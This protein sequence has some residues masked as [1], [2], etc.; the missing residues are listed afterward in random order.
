MKLLCIRGKKKSNFNPQNFL[1]IHVG[2]SG[3]QT[4]T[5]YKKKTSIAFSSLLLRLRSFQLKTNSGITFTSLCVFGSNRKYGQME[6]QL[7]VDYKIT[8]FSR[9]INYTLILSSNDFQD[10]EREREREREHRI[11]KPISPQLHPLTNEREMQLH[12]TYRRR[13]E[14]PTLRRAAP[15]YQ[16]H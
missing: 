6:N 5:S 1:T 11:P 4:A 8:H 2:V 7:H 13:S 14:V 3:E 15:S 12:P 9:K 10:S 16:I